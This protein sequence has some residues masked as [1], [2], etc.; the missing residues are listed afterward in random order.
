MRKEKYNNQGVRSRTNVRESHRLKK[1]HV[2]INVPVRPR[3]YKKR[4][5]NLFK[6]SVPDISTSTST[7]CSV[8]TLE[9]FC[10]SVLWCLLKVPIA[11]Y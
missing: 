2:Q 6:S 10:Q 9:K 4:L 5:H 3:T 8:E 7:I 11:A 1:N